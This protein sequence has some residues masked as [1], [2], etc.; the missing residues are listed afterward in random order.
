MLKNVQQYI[1]KIFRRKSKFK[2]KGVSDDII[3]MRFVHFQNK[4]METLNKVLDERR[5]I[6]KIYSLTVVEKRGFLKD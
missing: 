6:S 2:E 1:I 4:L 5:K 3:E